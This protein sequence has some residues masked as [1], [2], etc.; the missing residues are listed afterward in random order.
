M[1][2]R[3]ALTALLTF[4]SVRASAQE[5][6][7]IDV[8][9]EGSRA[10]SVDLHV[11]ALYFGPALTAGFRV[12]VPLVSNGFIPNLNNAIFLSVGADLYWGRYVDA[13][14]DERGVGFGI[15]LAFH[16]EFFFTDALS[17]FGEFGLNIYFPP[18]WIDGGDLVDDAGGWVIAAVGGRWKFAPHAALTV[19]A[20]T[21]YTTVGLTISF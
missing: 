1:T 8:P 20:G 13:G 18:S 7:R 16:W 6:T 10:V 4:V 9:H 17:A 12:N 21:P 11:G 15:P 5:P 3:L 14:Q 19:R 2:R